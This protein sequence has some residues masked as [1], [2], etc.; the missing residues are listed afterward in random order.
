MIGPLEKCMEGCGTPGY[1][2]P[3]MLKEMGYNKEIDLFAVGV[4]MHIILFG[5]Y[6]F[7][8]DDFYDI[9]R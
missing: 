7:E 2:A 5:R 1:V 8:G 6:P 9:C 4:I 3:E